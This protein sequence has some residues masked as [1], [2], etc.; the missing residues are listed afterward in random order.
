MDILKSG[1]IIDEEAYEMA[2][3]HECE[4]CGTLCDCGPHH[5]TPRGAGGSDVAENLIQLCPTCHRKAHNGD[6]DRDWLRRI[7]KR[8]IANQDL[9]GGIT[10]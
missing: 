2:R 3:S 1:R 10:W 8:R 4:I 5:I 9:L 6:F 7:A